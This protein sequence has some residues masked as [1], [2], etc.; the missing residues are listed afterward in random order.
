MSIPPCLRL[1]TFHIS[2]SDVHAPDKSYLPIYDTQFTV[3]AV[4]HLTGQFRESYRQ[5]RIYF[6]PFF[7]HPFEEPVLHAPA[8]YII[9]YHLYFHSLTGFVYQRIGY[10]HTERIVVENECI[11]IY[12]FFGV[13]DGREQSRE[14]LITGRVYFHF[15]VFERQRS[16]LFC[17]QRHQ[18]QVVFRQVQVRLTYKLQHGTLGQLV[19]TFLTDQF[20]L[21]YVLTEKEIEYDTDSRKESHHQKP[22]HRLSRLTETRF[23]IPIFG[24][25][26]F[27]LHPILTRLTYLLHQVLQTGF[28]IVHFKVT[29]QVC[30][31]FSQRHFFRFRLYLLT[32]LISAD[33]H[34]GSQLADLYIRMMGEICLAPE[35]VLTDMRLGFGQYL[36]IHRMME[37]KSVSLQVTG[38]I[39]RHGQGDMLP[40]FRFYI[41][42]SHFIAMA[43]HHLYQQVFHLT[44]LFGYRG[45]L[46]GF[47]FR[48]LF[49][50]APH[51]LLLVFL[52]FTDKLV[53]RTDQGGLRH[54]QPL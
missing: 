54:A 2:Q 41:G 47:L 46:H 18:C 15:M 3:V 6:Y 35:S 20:F 10:Q 12:V 30:H 13:M 32:K 31:L 19:Q 25:Q 45:T 8:S 21:T 29:D 34:L 5:E 26:L 40:V 7:A 16:V 38:Y 44:G 36:I 49:L 22:R 43:Y 28:Q 33:D 37:R 52:I 24:H 50:F 51:F 4:I 48:F 27:P 23:H 1:R 39:L 42:E 11:E 17:E 14:K 9:V 53:H